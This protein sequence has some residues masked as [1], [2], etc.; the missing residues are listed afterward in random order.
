M[1]CTHLH[2]F[3]VLF[4]TFFI[5]EFSAPG[6]GFQ[7]KPLFSPDR[8]YGTG[9][10]YCSAKIHFHAIGLYVGTVNH[11]TCRDDLVE[12]PR[13]APVRNNSAPT[14]R[15]S[16][17]IVQLAIKNF[18]QGFPDVFVEAH[19]HI[20]FLPQAANDFCRNHFSAAGFIPGHGIQC[21]RR[22]ATDQHFLGLSRLL[23]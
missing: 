18:T 8:K 2:T 12:D 19:T 20:S 13:H 21:R 17:S 11:D 14:S 22:Y 7:I 1:M 9:T 6:P 16:V 23:D 15:F 5:S 3:C 10:A 4:H